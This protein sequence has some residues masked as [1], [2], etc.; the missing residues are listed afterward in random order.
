MREVKEVVSAQVVERD[1]G[2]A[3]ELSGGLQLNRRHAHKK[4][5]NF[6]MHVLVYNGYHSYF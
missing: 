3:I 4:A 1:K 5:T 2:L 6:F